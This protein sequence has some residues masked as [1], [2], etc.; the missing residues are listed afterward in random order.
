MATMSN[1][2]D[3]RCEEHGW[4]LPCEECSKRY[5]RYRFLYDMGILVWAVL[6]C[7]LGL[8]GYWIFGLIFNF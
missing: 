5:C 7:L 8:L 4:Q 3:Q 1:D 6:T 2:D